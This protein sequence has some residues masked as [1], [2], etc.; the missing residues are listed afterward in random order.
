M[1]HDC[2]KAWWLPHRSG[3]LIG[4]HVLLF[5]SNSSWLLLY[6]L[7]PA[8]PA[9]WMVWCTV[10]LLQVFEVM[11]TVLEKKKSLA[12]MEVMDMISYLCGI[13]MIFNWVFCLHF[14]SWTYLKDVLIGMDIFNLCLFILVAVVHLLFL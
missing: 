8:S 14:Y 9:I 1:Q 3:S 10:I 4:W 7:V 2:W 5:V 6:K 12:T 13:V 11:G